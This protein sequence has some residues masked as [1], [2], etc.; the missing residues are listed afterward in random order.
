MSTSS[1][2][3]TTV[4][5]PCGEK[6]NEL[7]PRFNSAKL[8]FWR[9]KTDERLPLNFVLGILKITIKMKYIV[10]IMLITM[11]VDQEYP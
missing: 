9:D 7:L 8:E 2:C 10:I 4:C 3:G 5:P 6:K 11:F 1:S